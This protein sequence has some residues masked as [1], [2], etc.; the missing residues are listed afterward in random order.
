[1]IDPDARG[2]TRR[3]RH[4]PVSGERLSSGLSD[5]FRSLAA[6]LAAELQRRAPQHRTRS[7]ATFTDV[8]L[9]VDRGAW[10]RAV[11][12]ARA[13]AIQLHEH[14][15]PAPT[16]DATRVSATIALFEL[17]PDETPPAPRSNQEH[18]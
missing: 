15:L 10:W 3:Y 2:R 9:W 17:Q 18:E 6:A 16:S 12:A 1:V 4:D 13:V 14:A 8:E 7:A 5:D 11:E